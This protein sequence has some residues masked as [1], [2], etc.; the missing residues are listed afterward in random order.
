MVW[1]GIVRQGGRSMSLRASGRTSRD[2]PLSIREETD[3]PGGI[4]APLMQN[5][6]FLWSLVSALAGFLFGFD[7][8]VISGAEKTIEKLWELSPAMHGLAMS[9]ALWG[10]VL[11]SF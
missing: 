9:A 1:M 2:E 7:T 6:I 5:R 10:T 3:K 11:G 4:T 8:V